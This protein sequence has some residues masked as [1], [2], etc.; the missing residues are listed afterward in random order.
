LL[1]T[2]F[3][4][5]EQT[6]EMWELKMENGLFA[7]HEKCSWFFSFFFFWVYTYEFGLKVYNLLKLLTKCISKRLY[8]SL[9][10]FWRSTLEFEY[11]IDQI[12]KKIF[13]NIIF[14]IWIHKQVPLLLK[15][16]IIENFLKCVSMTKNFS[17]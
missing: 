13:P 1:P 2:P 16:K 14:T 3:D 6:F 15:Q 4:F 9:N 11:K 10:I 5:R 8:G 17:L 12:G 7:F